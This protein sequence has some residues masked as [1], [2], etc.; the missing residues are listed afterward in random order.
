MLVSRLIISRALLLPFFAAFL[1]AAGAARAQTPSAGKSFDVA[2]IKPSAPLDFAK[3]RADAQAGKLPRLGPH[4]D[5]S[6]AEYI[7]MT[8]KQLL[9]IAYHVKEYQVSGPDWIGDQRFDIEA[10]IP[11]GASRD[12]VP[13]MLQS[14]LKDRFKLTAHTSTEEHKVL[15]LIVGKS[16]PKL[17]E[18]SAPPA[19]D[20]NAPLKPG[21]QQMDGPDGPV[22]M[23]RN[24]DGSMTFNLGDKGTVTN[25]MNTQNQSLDIESDGVTMAGFADILTRVLQLGNQ[26][27]PQVVDQTG[28]K[29]YYE[30]TTEISFADLMNSARA[31][32]REAPPSNNANNNPAAA[33]SDPTGGQTVFASVEKLGLKLDER[34]APVEQLIIDHMEKS[35]TEN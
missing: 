3:L 35:P 5:A 32:N 24:S 30:V 22:R 7:Y 16:G 19:I 11:D 20:V 1:F 10:T 28:L 6:R 13:A 17:K 26:S 21:E 15:A 33:A 34:K 18:A 23:L 2:T 12:D 25:R 9:A 8:P 14:L 29:G 31:F 4:I 27:G